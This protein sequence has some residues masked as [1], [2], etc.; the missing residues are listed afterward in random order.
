MRFSTSI[1]ALAIA[2]VSSLVVAACGE[3]ATATVSGTVRTAT[4]AAIAGASVK[5]ESV[6]ATTGADGRFELQNLPVGR[7]TI[8]TSAP[9]FDPR[10]EGVGLVE[11][12]NAHD[13]VLTDQTIYTYGNVRAYLPPGIAEYQAHGGG[14][15]ALPRACRRK[16]GTHRNNDPG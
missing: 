13:V 4:G 3:G 12:S 7:V 16:G 5:T 1:R 10:S 9:R 6:T 8:S 2:L 15:A 11:G 14:E